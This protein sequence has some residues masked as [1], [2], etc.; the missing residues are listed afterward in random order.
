M[1]TIP[2]AIPKRPSVALLAIL[3]LVMIVFSYL[4]TL[5]VGIACAVL[6]FL[7][8]EHLGGLAALVL[9]ALGLIMSGTI[10]WSLIPRWDKLEIKGVSIVPDRHPRLLAL[11]RGIAMDLGE[12]L[13]SFV[14]LIP[15]SN[16]FVTERGDLLGAGGQRV[17]G[18]GLPLMASMTIGE[19]RAVLAH[20]FAHFYS[21]D[22]RLGPRVYQVRAAMSRTIRNLGADSAVIRVLTRFAIAAVAYTVV[23]HGLIAYWKLFLRL[24]QLIARRQEY[25][26]DELACYVAGARAMESGLQKLVKITSVSQSF[27]GAV[28]NPV[29]QVGY[30][31]PLVEGLNRYHQSPLINKAAAE[32]FTRVIGNEKTSAYDTHPPIKLRLE[33]VAALKTTREGSDDSL[34]AV[35]LLEDVDGLEKQLLEALLPEPKAALKP[36]HWDNAGPTV[37]VPA[38]R[39]FVEEHAAALAGKTI[40]SLPEFS[41]NLPQMGAQMRDPPGVLLTREQR[42]ERAANLLSKALTLVMID[43][44]WSLHIQ[45]GEFHLSRREERLLPGDIISAMRAGKLGT[46]PWRDWCAKH[47]LSSE[48]PLTARG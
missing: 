15:D 35:S 1:S 43:N 18:L 8:A 4:F 33:R 9:I 26:A 25:R 38:W 39:N 7:V 47:D 20:E 2:I 14:Y 27:W 44:G 23:V 40:A 24:T 17:M 31:P 11:I 10:L 37:W 6:P 21:G 22:T 3:G 28:V 19:F 42:A 16:A 13:P 41:A 46:G 30:R 48:I 36:M 12:P 34:S 32:A 5:M 45:P 29:L